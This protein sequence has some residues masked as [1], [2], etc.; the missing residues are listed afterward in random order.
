VDDHDQLLYALSAIV[1]ER[2]DTLNIS[3]IEFARLTGLHRT[4]IGELEKGARNVS[5][6]NLSHLAA[7]LNLPASKLL[8]LVEKRVAAEGP[9]KLK[10]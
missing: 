2:R 1:R 10:K 7:A 9:F 8:S 5:V 4:Y 6:K 3:Q